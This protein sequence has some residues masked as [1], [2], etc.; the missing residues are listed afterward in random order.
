MF[1]FIGMAVVALVVWSFAKAIFRGVVRGQRQRAIYY[2][3]SLG[4]PAR[5]AAEMIHDF[6]TLKSV[7]YHL[8]QIVPD[9]KTLE[10]YK[11]FG[12]AIY[13]LHIASV[14]LNEY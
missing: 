1:E 2:A 7:R 9:F 6:D 4:V 14:K 3:I 5:F 13:A 11:Q 12:H 8:A 10:V